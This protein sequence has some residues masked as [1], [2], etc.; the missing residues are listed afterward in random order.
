MTLD[1]MIKICEELPGARAVLTIGHHL[2]Y[3]IGEKSFV[4]FSQDQVPIPC[5]FKCRKEDFTL[6]C[7]TEGFD[8][9][10]Y[11]GRFGWVRCQDIG[12]LSFQE[13]KT[14]IT[15]SYYVVWEKLPEKIK[16]ATGRK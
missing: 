9:A 10:P 6:L 13:A 8:K 3:N 14:Y 12:R 5:N 2:T 11:I 15:N 1:Q 4:W 16:S 7:E